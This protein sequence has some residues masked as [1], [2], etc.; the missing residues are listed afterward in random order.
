MRVLS[1]DIGV[2]NL[3]YCDLCHVKEKELIINDWKV[4]DISIT[5]KKYDLN[6]IIIV[7]LKTLEDIKFDYS[8]YDYVLIENQPA[9]VNPIMK[10]IQIIIF[11]YFHLEKMRSHNDSLQIVL[12]SAGNKLKTINGIDV[13][14]AS[15]IKTQA[16]EKAKCEKGYKYNK[17]LSKLL[18]T[19]CL[20][21]NVTNCTDFCQFYEDCKKKDDLSD[22]FLQAASMFLK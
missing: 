5:D 14:S 21:H 12:S 9:V 4:L 19:H 1:F 15:C 11:S 3:A 6:K 8:L 17:V 16:I 10:S 22:C 13:N 18:M 2:K 20:E 7:L